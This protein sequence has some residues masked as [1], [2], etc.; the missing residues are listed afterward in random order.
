MESI[1]LQ[2]LF[3]TNRKTEKFH[4]IK[5]YPRMKK[6]GYHTKPQKKTNKTKQNGIFWGDPNSQTQAKEIKVRG[7]KNSK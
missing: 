1:Y 6:L 2:A 5:D 7:K 3:E 4:N